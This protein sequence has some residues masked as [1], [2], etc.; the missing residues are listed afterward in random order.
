MKMGRVR[1]RPQ[2][3]CENPNLNLTFSHTPGK[4]EDMIKRDITGELWASAGEYPA[5]T[6]CGP[7]QSGKTTL[8]QMTFPD[9]LYYSLE[10]PDLRMAVETD[11]RG[12]LANLPEGCV[13]DEFSAFR[14]CSL[15]FKT[16][17]TR[18]KKRACSF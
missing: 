15:T 5:V 11:P 4:L 13:L 3:Y 2:T 7:R 12:F 10:D 18:P 9:K 17:S 6:V 14:S 16:S 8:V 1:T